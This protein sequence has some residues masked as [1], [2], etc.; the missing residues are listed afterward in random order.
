[1]SA[2]RGITDIGRGGI[3]GSVRYSTFHRRKKVA[4]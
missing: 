3:P 4:A 2:F 1:M